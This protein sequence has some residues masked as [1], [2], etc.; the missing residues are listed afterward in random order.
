VELSGLPPGTYMW[1]DTELSDEVL[2]YKYD[3]LI[4]D[5]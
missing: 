3:T 2:Q 5:S 4:G 1:Y